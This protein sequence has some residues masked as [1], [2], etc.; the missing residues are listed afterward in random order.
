M[1][2][3]E[4]IPLAQVLFVVPKRAFKKAHDRNRLRR[5]MKEAY[6]LQK[7]TLGSP[8]NGLMLAFVYA[9]ADEEPYQAIAKSLTKL[10]LEIREVRI[11]PPV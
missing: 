3:D 5:R 4:S 7:H 11:L 9:A 6:R 2:A 1:R 8:G 10:L